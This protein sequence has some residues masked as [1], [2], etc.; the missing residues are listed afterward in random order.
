M[1]MKHHLQDLLEPVIEKLGYEAVRIMTIGQKNQ[2]LQIMIDTLDGRDITVDDCATVSRAVSEVLDEKDPIDDRY[3]LEVSSPGLDRPLTKPAHFARFAGYEARIET[4][5][6]VAGRKRFKGVI[7][8]VDAENNVS[9]IMDGENYLIPFADIS[10][11]KL[12]LTDELLQSFEEKAAAS[13]I[14]L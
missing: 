2:T 11:A 12:V 9:L 7:S 8:A 4:S 14:E 13:E 1:Q 6:E 5:A 10:K 3:N